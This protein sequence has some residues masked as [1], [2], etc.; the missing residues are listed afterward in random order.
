MKR[1]T[2]S[3]KTAVIALLVLLM[4]FLWTQN[5]KLRFSEN[6]ASATSLQHLDSSFWIFTDSTNAH[7]EIIA[8]SSYLSPVSMTLVADSKAYS[9]TANKALTTRLWNNTLPLVKEVFSSSYA[10]SL[11]NADKWKNGLKSKDFILIEFP[12]PIP[13]MTLCAFENKTQ[14]LV[15]KH[16]V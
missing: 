8:D 2:E 12:S 1:L 15:L 5:M 10:S 6:T 13:Y 14:S 16:Q 11:A 9:S 4:L 7:T 3:I